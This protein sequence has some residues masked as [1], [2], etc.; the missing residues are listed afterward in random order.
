MC[1]RPQAICQHASLLHRYLR[2]PTRRGAMI[3]SRWCEGGQLKFT[4][5]VAKGLTNY[6]CLV[7]SAISLSRI[8]GRACC[9]KR[10]LLATPRSSRY[11]KERCPRAQD[12]RK[13]CP[14]SGQIWS[15]RSNIITKH[16]EHCAHI[17]DLL[18][19]QAADL[20]HSTSEKQR[21][22]TAVQLETTS[23]SA[24]ASLRPLLG[25]A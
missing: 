16:A 3:E 22:I 6:V 25:L 17:I 18:Q 7:S 2:H 8:S 12:L 21:G 5:G 15:N 11:C 23:L 1:D 19:L 4:K 13:V 10:P 20:R 14:G 24:P 9:N